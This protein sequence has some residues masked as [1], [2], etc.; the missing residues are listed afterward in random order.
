M[1][2][3]FTVEK[4]NDSAK[5]LG[6]GLQSDRPLIYTRYPPIDRISESFYETPGPPLHVV[7]HNRRNRFITV[8]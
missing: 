3:R 1:Y 8:R 5:K 2:P 6:G 7:Y 4:F